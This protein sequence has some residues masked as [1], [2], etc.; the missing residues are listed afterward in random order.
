MEHTHLISVCVFCLLCATHIHCSEYSTRASRTKIKS[1][2]ENSGRNAIGA[3]KGTED[4]FPTDREN[5]FGYSSLLQDDSVPSRKDLLPSSDRPDRRYKRNDEQ[6]RGG[7]KTH[8]ELLF[9]KYKNSDDKI[10]L[11]GLKKM[12]NNLRLNNYSLEERLPGIDGAPEAIE[13]QKHRG[14]D[15]EEIAERSKSSIKAEEHEP[16]EGKCL[17]AED[18]V[19]SPSH[20]RW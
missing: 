14:G 16:D 3:S 13:T 9:D 15:G 12:L 19:P 11:N 10:D 5:P 18:L 2:A 8:A 17:S 4:A 1:K 7:N 20:N 6:N